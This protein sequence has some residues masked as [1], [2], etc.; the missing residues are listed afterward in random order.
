MDFSLSLSLPLFTARIKSLGQIESVVFFSVCGFALIDTVCTVVCT[1][2][3][4]SE[5]DSIEWRTFAQVH[6]MV[7]C[8]SVNINILYRLYILCALTSP[9]AESRQMQWGSHEFFFFL[10]FYLLHFVRSL[11]R[12]FNRFIRSFFC[13][14]RRLHFPKSGTRSYVQFL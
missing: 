8:A 12:S 13:F 3:I 7:Q 5:E 1:A 2:K 10:L 9:S 6:G 11:F 4:R 14:P